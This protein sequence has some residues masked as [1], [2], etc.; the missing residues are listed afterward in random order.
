MLKVVTAR[1]MQLI[2]R[3]TIERYGVDGKILMERAGLAV[4]A[5]IKDIF[6]DK[7]VVVLCGSGNNGGDGFVVARIIHNEGRD[8]QVFLAANPKDLKGD[9]KINYQAAKQFGVKIQPLTKF[10]TQNSKLLTPDS[11]IVDALLGTGL[12]K[13]VKSPLS[14]VIKKINRL[15]CPVISIDIP[16]GI[17][18]DN[19]QIM[20]SAVK[21]HYT[22]TFGLPKRGHLL[23]PGAEYA[24]EL[25]IEDI[26]FP[27]KLLESENIKVNLLQR[28]DILSFLSERQRYRLQVPR[29]SA[30]NSDQ[31][32]HPE[33]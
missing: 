19:G 15:K 2:D 24:G 10:L 8:V 7:K 22:V 17:S 27:L 1:E 25:F 9:A 29:A 13:E 11:I 14:Q 4:T 31:H 33:G 26:G 30:S 5:R 16:S 3:T 23:Y 28:E 21:A 12:K 6:Q 20:G 18:S 32:R